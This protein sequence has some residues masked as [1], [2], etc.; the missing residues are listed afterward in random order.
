LGSSSTTSSST[1]SS[2]KPPPSL[3]TLQSLKIRSFATTD[4]DEDQPVGVDGKMLDRSTSSLDPLRHAVSYGG[5]IDRDDA[6][7]KK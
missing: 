3:S 6:N 5:S 1:S 7:I 2:L 4:F